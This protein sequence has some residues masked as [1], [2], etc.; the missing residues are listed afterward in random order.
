VPG[1]RACRVDTRVDAWPTR[2]WTPRE[3]W[4][5]LKPPRINQA[6]LILEAGRILEPLGVKPPDLEKLVSEVRA[7]GTAS[8][9]EDEKQMIAI[10]AKAWVV[11]APLGVEP[12][13]FRRLVENAVRNAWK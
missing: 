5:S 8:W 13:D 2:A 12:A 11:L 4:L 10:V 6:I 7:R 9:S 3:P 1:T